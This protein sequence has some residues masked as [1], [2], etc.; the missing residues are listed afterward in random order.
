MF[1]PGLKF[2]SKR[3]TPD[4]CFWK[5]GQTA[6]HIVL[7]SKE[8]LS[9][10]NARGDDLGRALPF[11]HRRPLGLLTSALLDHTSAT[12][13][14]KTPSPPRPISC[15]G[16]REAF[17]RGF[18]SS[19]AALPGP[20]A[21]VAAGAVA[22]RFASWRESLQWQHHTAVSRFVYS[23]V[24]CLGGSPGGVTTVGNLTTFL[25]E[26]IRASPVW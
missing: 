21:R 1:E 10:A 8:R 6:F 4:A 14:A 23:P 19:R 12:A 20:N 9:K 7:G 25:I 24:E 11:P 2:Y 5:Y 26:S 3:Q 18:S 22:P 15:S 13:L 16:A 17:P